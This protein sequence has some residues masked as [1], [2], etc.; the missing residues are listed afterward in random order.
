MVKERMVCMKKVFICCE[1]EKRE[2]SIAKAKSSF[3]RAVKIVED[4]TVADM[5]YVVGTVTPQMQIQIKQLE[6][7][8]VK[9]VKVNDNLINE[10]LYEKMIRGAV[11]VQA[12]EEGWKRG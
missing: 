12:R 3:Y 8:G 5:A 9:I 6:E 1:E 7:A 2:R 11:R 4:V 10:E